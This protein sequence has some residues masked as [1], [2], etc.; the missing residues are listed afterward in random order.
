M[1]SYIPFL[2]LRYL[3]FHKVS[4]G[5]GILGVTLGV[6]MVIVV[7]G[8]MDGF[9]ARLT[10]SL[11]ENTAAV[12]VARQ[13]HPVTL[14]A[15]ASRNL[16]QGQPAGPDVFWVLAWTAVIVAVAAPMAMRLYYR[17]R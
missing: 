15:R 11:I 2:S 4:S 7:V 16:M 17:E 8:V 10:G 14:L 13:T 1:K 9:Q 12:V 6:G 5:L 3:L